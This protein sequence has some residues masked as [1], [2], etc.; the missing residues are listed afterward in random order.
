M[1]KKLRDLRIT[2]FGEKGSL[3][4]THLI[5]SGNGDDGSGYIK[6]IER[7]V[8]LYDMEPD[9]QASALILWNYS[10]DNSVKEEKLE[11]PKPPIIVD[12]T[13]LESDNS[14]DGDK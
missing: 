9:H 11:V 7:V 13:T 1:A 4:L 8:A 6:P 14:G 2:L 5:Y 3:N 12:P 10:V